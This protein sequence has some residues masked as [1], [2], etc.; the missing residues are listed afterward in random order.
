MAHI[1]K[2]KVSSL[3]GRPLTS[4]E[5]TNFDIWLNIAELRLSDLICG[6][7]TLI[8]P[9]PNDLALV[10]ARLFDG[11]TKENNSVTGNIKSKRVEDFQITYREDSNDVYSEI[12]NANSATIGKYSECG[13][14]IRHGKTIYDDGIRCV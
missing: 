4:E 9:L 13:S 6:D 1:T 8:D 12:V 10:L 2:E 11:I 3:L 5:T 7:V 14:G